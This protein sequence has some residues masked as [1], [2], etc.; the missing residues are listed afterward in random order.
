MPRAGSSGS[1]NK[2]TDAEF[3]FIVVVN[4]IIATKVHLVKYFDCS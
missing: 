4:I 3:F 1:K 2:N